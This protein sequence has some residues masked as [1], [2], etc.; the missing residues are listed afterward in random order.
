MDP[1]QNAKF[2]LHEAAREGNGELCSYL[3]DEMILMT[4]IAQV[5]EF[6]LSVSDATDPDA[7]QNPSSTLDIFPT[8]FLKLCC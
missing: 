3:L 4:L 6:L 2:P 7:P 1:T 8:N 5:V